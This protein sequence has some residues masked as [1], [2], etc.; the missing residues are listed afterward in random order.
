METNLITI[1]LQ[2]DSPGYEISPARVPLATLAAFASEVRDFL[3]GSG[4][5]GDTDAAEVA[6]VDSSLGSVYI[7]FKKCVYILFFA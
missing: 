3:K 7:Y 6:V 2:D 5:D 1:S 4:K